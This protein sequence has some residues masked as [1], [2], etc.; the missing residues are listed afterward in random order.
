MLLG[1]GGDPRQAGT[2]SYDAGPSGSKRRDYY[3]SEPFDLCSSAVLMQLPNA[4]LRHPPDDRHPSTEEVDAGVSPPCNT[5]MGRSRV[6]RPSRAQPCSDAFS[7]RPSTGTFGKASRRPRQQDPYPGY[8]PPLAAPGGMT[9]HENPYAAAD[10]EAT[11]EGGGV[12]EQ[13]FDGRTRP[14]PQRRTST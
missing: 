3:L 2:D 6:L 11:D 12:Y 1:C 7:R 10:D 13:P 9:L 4:S 5:F 8:G 14:V